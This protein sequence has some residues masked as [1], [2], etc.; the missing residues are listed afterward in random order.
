M[1]QLDG[2]HDSSDDEE[3]EEEEDDDNDDDDVEDKDEEENDENEA[4]AEEV[5]SVVYSWSYS[6][7]LSCM[8]TF[9]FSQKCYYYRWMGF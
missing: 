9:V 6:I 4:G 2:Q 1:P 7:V 3:E 5:G 8:I